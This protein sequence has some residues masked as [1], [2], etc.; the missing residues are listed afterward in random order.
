MVDIGSLLETLNKLQTLAGFLFLIPPSLIIIFIIRLF[1][2]FPIYFYTL[3]DTKY[4][5]SSLS[6][7]ISVKRFEV[8]ICIQS[9]LKKNEQ[10]KTNVY[11][12]YVTFAINIT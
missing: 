6:V 8:I 3:C 1:I 7:S 2:L 5:A 11:T 9:I 10:R 12:L 4:I